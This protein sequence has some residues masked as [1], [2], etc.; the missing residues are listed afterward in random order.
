MTAN[1]KIS[2]GPFR[3]GKYVPAMVELSMLVE[4][5]GRDFVAFNNTKKNKSI[6]K[7]T[8]LSEIHK[9]LSELKG[10]RNYPEI[11]G[12][13]VTDDYF[14]VVAR[15]LKGSNNY[16]ALKLLG[17]SNEIDGDPE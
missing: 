12:F 8:V 2:H 11:K 7:G 3:G 10:N 4:R 5:K 1:T 17:F 15:A 13:A 16:E 9:E 14:F 6:K